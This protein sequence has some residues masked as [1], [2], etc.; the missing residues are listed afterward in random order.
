MK[1]TLHKVETEWIVTT[2]YTETNENGIMDQLVQTYYQLHPDDVE[3]IDSCFTN[4][5]KQDIDFQII[6][7]Q[8]MDGVAKYAKLINFNSDQNKNVNRLEIIDQNG[9]SYVKYDCNIELSYQDT[10]KTL[11]IFVKQN[12]PYVSDDFQIGPDGAYESNEIVSK[13]I[14]EYPNDQELGEQ[15]RKLYY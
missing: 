1:G 15:I 4:K 5:F 12:V 13:L 10:G 2:V 7:H 9:R 3:M 14:K 8:K 6:E 11:K